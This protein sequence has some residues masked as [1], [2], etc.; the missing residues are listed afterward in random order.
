[1]LPLINF[2]KINIMEKLKYN[3]FKLIHRDGPHGDQCSSYD[4][5]IGDNVTLSEFLKHLNPEEWGKVHF[6]EFDYNGRMINI[7]IEYSYGKITNMPDKALPYMNKV[8]KSGEA[9]GGWSLMDYW[10]KFE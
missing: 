2:I 8:I 9:N 4:I 5:E 3:V 1:M 7:N 6:V 10:I